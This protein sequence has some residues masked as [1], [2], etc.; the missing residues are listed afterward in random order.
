MEREREREREREAPTSPSAK[1]A[2][3]ALSIYHVTKI[4]KV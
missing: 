3:G 4:N 1:V 2:A